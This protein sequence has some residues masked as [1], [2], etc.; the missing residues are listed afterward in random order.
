MTR[1]SRPAGPPY[2]GDDDPPDAPAPRF[3]PHDTGPQG[4]E[5]RSLPPGYRPP[6]PPG[7]EIPPPQ[8]YQTPPAPGYQAAGQEPP[9]ASAQPAPPQQGA[10]GPSFTPRPPTPSP[11]EPGQGT[12]ASQGP[13]HGKTGGR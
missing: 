12:R 13:R 2:P 6:P 5:T 3:V 10:P 7:Y 11:Q 4:P 1:P 8:G 9:F